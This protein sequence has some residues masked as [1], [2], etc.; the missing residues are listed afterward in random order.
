[1]TIEI[2][3]ILSKIMPPEA[4]IREMLYFL[5]VGPR[6]NQTNTE[7]NNRYLDELKSMREQAER[8]GR[9]EVAHAFAFLIKNRQAGGKE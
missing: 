1:M 7:L 9:P 2:A 5:L 4:S 3:R 8:Q 6:D